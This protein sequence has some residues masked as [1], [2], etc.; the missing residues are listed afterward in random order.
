MHD[1]TPIHPSITPLPTVHASSISPIRLRPA[2]LHRDSPAINVQIRTPR[3][4]SVQLTDGNACAR[5][6]PL[7][8]S[9]PEQPPFFSPLRWRQRAGSGES[10]DGMNQGFAPRE[11]I[12]SGHPPPRANK[13][14]PNPP[15][16]V[17]S[18]GYKQR[19][20][21]S[22]TRCPCHRRAVLRSFRLQSA[23]LPLCR[24]RPLA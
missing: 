18:T 23:L 2:L 19:R 21:G 7:E 14:K 11:V 12:R 15:P 22:G 17:S 3:I 13:R 24:R 6:P 4:H 5:M 16:I 10:A 9:L 20:R 8:C 1:F